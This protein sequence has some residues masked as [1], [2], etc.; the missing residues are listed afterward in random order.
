M[1][2][3]IL[4]LL[5]CI[6][7][8]SSAAIPKTNEQSKTAKPTLVTDKKSSESKPESAINKVK[9]TTTSSTAKKPEPKKTEVKES[10]KKQADKPKPPPVESPKQPDLQAGPI[11]H[12]NK[13]TYGQLETQSGGSV[14]HFLFVVI[15]III[16][17][18]VAHTYR[19]KLMGFFIR[20]GGTTR[21]GGSVRYRRLS[22]G[23]NA[24]E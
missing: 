5:L 19:K 4:P 12:K 3:R 11:E 13:E 17:A 24:I 15:V 2:L 7:L 1:Y 14:L 9:H 8:V 21:R 6:Y 20:R 22:T 18:C 23:E 16:G 10:P